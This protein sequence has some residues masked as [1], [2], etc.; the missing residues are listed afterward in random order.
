MNCELTLDGGLVDGATIGSGLR[1]RRG[2]GWKSHC[3]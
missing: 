3:N 1:L 2:S